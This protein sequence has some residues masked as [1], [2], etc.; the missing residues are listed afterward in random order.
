MKSTIWYSL[1]AAGVIITDRITKMWAL[2]V[3]VKPYVFTS[4][5]SC[6][7]AFNRGISW[8]ML[9]ASSTLGFVLVT[10]LVLLVVGMVAWQ[11]WQGIMAKRAVTGEVLVLA[12]AL[13]NVADRLI[14]GGVIDFIALEYHNYH[15][16]LF[17]IA[18]MAIVCGVF[19]MM[20]ETI[21]S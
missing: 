8:S 13:S 11:A 17:N 19:I 9:H 12:G 15:W 21:R 20:Y 4:W 1:L 10:S 18:D 5:L 7:L 6:S 2:S 3:C 14:Y 16:P